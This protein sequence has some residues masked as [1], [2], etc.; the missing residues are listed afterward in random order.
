VTGVLADII[1]ATCEDLAAR[2]AARPS[3]MLEALARNRVPSPERFLAALSRPG[4][5]NIVA[6]CKR[7]S[8]S[9]G[10]LRAEYD[11]AA[12][13]R[14]YEQGGAAAA[15]VLTEPRF[16]GG[17]LEHLAAV[18]DGTSL[19]LLRKDFVVSEYQLL[20][21]RAAGADAVLLI[22]AALDAARL[23]RLVAAA[24]ALGL[25]PLVEVHDEAELGRALNAGAAIVGVNSRDL[26]SLAVDLGTAERLGPMIPAHVVALAE[27]GIRTREDVVRL[28][29]AGYRAFLVGEQVVTSGDPASAVRRLASAWL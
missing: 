2:R 19:P 12:L 28:G 3:A 23:A 17:A 22:A 5:P 24:E 25:A 9:K 10:V 29:K 1:A 7:R 27:S 21:A 20:E 8:P 18:R 13:G 14:A 15:S 6:E 11:P 26:R 4:R 16:F